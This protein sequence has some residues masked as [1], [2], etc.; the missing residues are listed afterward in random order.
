MGEGETLLCGAF[1]CVRAHFH[2]VSYSRKRL[3]SARERVKTGDGFKGLPFPYPTYLMNI[4]H[5]SRFTYPR[6]FSTATISH[7]FYS[8]FPRRP[9]T[10]FYARVS[11]LNEPHEITNANGA[12]NGRSKNFHAREPPRRLREVGATGECIFLAAI[13]FC[14]VSREQLSSLQQRKRRGRILRAQRA[15]FGAR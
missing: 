2:S 13:A 4:P 1:S 14:F 3:A 8:R 6:A 9:A 5:R 11:F 7:A 15:S 10:G 12:R